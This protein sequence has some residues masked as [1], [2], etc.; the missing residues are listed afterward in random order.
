[1]DGAYAAQEHK[2]SVRYIPETVKIRLWGKAGGR[3]EYEGCNEPLWV[4]NTTKAEFNKAYIAHIVA[5]KP[6]GPRG[7]KV[8]SPKLKCDISNLMLLCDPHHRLIDREDVSGHP[9]ERLQQ[10]KRKHEERVELATGIQPVKRSEILL[11]GERIGEHHVQL[12]YESAA[13]AIIPDRYPARSRAIELG[14]RNS[15]FEDTSQDYWQVEREHLT[16]QFAANVKSLLRYSRFPN[17]ILN[18]LR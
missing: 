15:A 1:V 8:L 4:D 17:Q 11:Y 7:D 13:K 18:S 2:L 3:C 12:N 6:G 5:D 14:L 16:R 10:M 9:T